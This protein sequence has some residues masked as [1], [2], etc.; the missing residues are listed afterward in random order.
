MRKDLGKDWDIYFFN[1][2]NLGLHRDGA[3]LYRRFF[4]THNMRHSL[5]RR[6]QKRSLF[7]QTTVSYLKGNKCECSKFDML[8]KQTQRGDCLQFR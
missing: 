7:D 3:F 4:W 8:C 2:F 6:L 1:L 5:Q